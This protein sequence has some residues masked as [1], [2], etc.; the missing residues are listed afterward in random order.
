MPHWPSLEGRSRVSLYVESRGLHMSLI[1]IVNS[2]SMGL[3]GPGRP[4]L[5]LL[6]AERGGGETQRWLD[7]PVSI[8]YLLVKIN[9][10]VYMCVV[11]SGVHMPCGG[12]RTILGIGPHLPPCLRRGLLCCAIL[13]TSGWLKCDSPF[14]PPRSQ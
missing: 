14:A 9:L 12:Q 10:C 3:G 4:H 1:P 5:T 13:C 7:G 11:C 8:I 6:G 2:L